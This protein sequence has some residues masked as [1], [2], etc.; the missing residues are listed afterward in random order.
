M[1]KI[2]ATLVLTIALLRPATGHADEPKV[3]DIPPGDDKIVVVREGDKAPFTGQLF[4][5]A[6][7]LR[8][9]NWLQQYRLRLQ[10]DTTLQQRINQADA[11][12]CADQK[13]AAQE[14]YKFV[15]GEYQSQVQ[16]RD[17]KISELET[18]LDHPP[19]YRTV[20]FGALLGVVLTGGLFG[21]GVWAASH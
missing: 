5:Q 14:K 20:W 3:Q 19:F 2:I 9:A 17:V 7:A 12:L 18:K 21:M 10:A 15:T 11:Q 6:T 1:H 4:D 16:Q 8:W 13:T